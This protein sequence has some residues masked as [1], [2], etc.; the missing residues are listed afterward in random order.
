MFRPYRRLVSITLEHVDEVA[1]PPEPSPPRATP[2]LLPVVEWLAVIVCCIVVL[3]G[4]AP[5]LVLT[6]SLPLGTD[7]TGHVVVPWIDHTNLG[8][9]LP[10]S[11]SQAMFNGFPVNQLY[12]WLPSYLAAL[13]SFV[14]PLAIAFKLIVVLPLVMLPWATWRAARWAALP[15]PV[16]V[17]L[18]LG[19]L[20]F[21]YD[22]SCTSC[23]GNITSTINGEYSF[24]W[25]M[26]FAILALGAIDRLAR[27]GRGVLF[28]A[29]LCA[30]TAFSHPLPTIWLVLGA[31]VI[32]IS[33][34]I[35]SDRSRA[36]AFGAAA[37][38]GALLASMWWVPFLSRRDWMPVVGLVR[39]P[40]ISLQTWLL[41]ASTPW[42]IGVSVLAL[43]GAVWA[44][45][46]RAW[47]L[48]TFGVLSLVALAAFWRFA[49]GGPFYSI[50]LLPFWS[51]GRWMLAVAGFAWVIS[52][53]V[54]R[55]RTDREAGP[56]IRIAP[57]VWLVGSVLIIG[58][59]WGWWGAS[60]AATSTTDGQAS[61]LG[62]QTTVTKQSAGLRAV[63]GGFAAR[64]DYPELQAVQQLVKDVGAQRGCGTLMWDGGDPTAPEAPVLGDPQVFWQAA[65]WT[66]GCITSADGVLVDSSMTAASMQMTKQLVSESGENLLPNRP[67]FG[68][69]LAGGG[70]QRMQEQG[71]RYFLTR[72]GTPALDASATKLLTLVAKAGP[73]EMWE[74]QKGVAAASLTALPSVF[75]PRLSDG[76]WG[77]VSDLYFGAS[78]SGA[79]PLVQDGPSTWPTI[80][81]QKL[82]P[83]TPSNPAGVTDV[84]VTDHQV[85]FTVART[86]LPV[87]VRV[88][89]YPGWTV[90]GADSIHRA[91]P[92]Y[93]VVVPTE[94]RVVL[95][96]GRTTIDWIAIVLGFSGLG[97][98]VGML[99]FRRLETIG[100]AAD[101]RA[102]PDLEDE[103]E[104]ADISNPENE[105]LESGDPATHAIPESGDAELAD[106]EGELLP[107]FVDHSSAGPHHDE[108][109]A[110]HTVE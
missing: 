76:D 1:S 108:P 50:R 81:L 43:A 31:V 46:T 70:A 53:V 12:P 21:L 38:I 3:A 16:P 29:A 19:T 64:S 84:T 80:S 41:P 20:P 105:E 56:D 14:M 92:N 103:D 52:V 110:H 9:W 73:W 57:V 27:D 59:T 61:V 35:W 65:I 4:V 11:W 7:L 74:V 36:V 98:M 82:P 40:E 6:D 100:V 96:K 72:G 54:A 15:S 71:I 89:A 22:T 10:G 45:R 91:S 83:V 34:E 62:L 106:D 58:T 87:I 2:A 93:M 109:E 42:E 5:D 26:F 37:L 69:D 94:G 99:V 17:L 101:A 67:T 28:S 13:L 49:E 32:A 33:R 23:G 51:F 55:V 18:A 48:I 39:D 66:E 85:A 90:T 95:N 78:N 8:A 107:G 102:Y 68:Y 104:D 60:T 63:L 86:G 97:L 75:D 77:G 47:L 24:A 44:V 25:G 88:S 79:V 30:A